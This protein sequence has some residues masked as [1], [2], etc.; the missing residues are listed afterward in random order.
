MALVLKQ[1]NLP[2]PAFAMTPRDV[3]SVTYEI[4]HHSD[5]PPDQPIADI[6]AE[7]RA[8]GWAMCGY[9]FIIAQD[10]TA[11]QCRPMNVVPA[12]AE[13]LNTPSVDVCL[14]GDFQPG[15]DG[16]QSTVPPAQLQALKDLSVYL[17]QQYP[18][19]DSTIGHRDVSGI[20]GD[21]S[22][23]TAC[24]GDILYAL[25]PD[26]KNYTAGKLDIT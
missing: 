16:F 8:E 5:G 10:G 11:W 12:A 9:N 21:P 18:T 23:A 26:V 22:V 3:S 4:V 15:T 6:D 25:L 13:D 20:V 2:P 17:H 24:P 1:A 19:I 14:L 7:H